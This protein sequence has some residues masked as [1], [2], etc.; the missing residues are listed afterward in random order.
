MCEVEFWEV[1][2]RKVRVFLKWFTLD[3]Q[4]D[5]R[6]ADLERIYKTPLKFLVFIFELLMCDLVCPGLYSYFVCR[7]QYFPTLTALTSRVMPA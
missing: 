7:R 6:L 1:F 2:L 5:C 4:V 3:P